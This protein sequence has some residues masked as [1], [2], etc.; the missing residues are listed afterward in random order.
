MVLSDWPWHLFDFTLI[1]QFSVHI[2]GIRVEP[3]NL[4]S[5]YVISST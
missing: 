3:S 4:D 1:A 2:I 5:V